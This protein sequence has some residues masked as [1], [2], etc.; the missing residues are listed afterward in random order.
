MKTHDNDPF[1]HNSDKKLAQLAMVCQTRDR[2]SS[3]IEQL[4]ETGIVGLIDRHQEREEQI[5]KALVQ[6]RKHCVD[7][8]CRE[9]GGHYKKIKSDLASLDATQNAKFSSI[10][11]NTQLVGKDVKALQLSLFQC[12][13]AALDSAD[14]FRREI[15]MKR[16]QLDD[17][18]ERAAD[19][20]SHLCSE[21]RE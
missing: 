13:S 2:R 8:C 17:P 18:P 1:K 16:R 15:E 20:R 12:A 4:C 11:A 19:P 5:A 3:L 6:F 9:W 10:I 14:S 7:G 21:G